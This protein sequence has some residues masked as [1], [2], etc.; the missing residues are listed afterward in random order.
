[1]PAERTAHVM[2][3]PMNVVGNGPSNGRKLRTGS[4]RQKKAASDDDRKNLRQ[5]YAGFDLY[6]AVL[7][8]SLDKTIQRVHVQH[9]IAGR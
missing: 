6:D 4:N 9:L 3:L 1:M 2:I 7:P 5:A 8:V